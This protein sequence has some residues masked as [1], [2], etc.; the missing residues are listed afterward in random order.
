M[1]LLRFQEMQEPF[2]CS[3][4]S[5]HMEVSP[6]YITEPGKEVF[7]MARL[8]GKERTSLVHDEKAAAQRK[9]RKERAEQIAGGSYRPRSTVFSDK[10]RKKQEAERKRE[11]RS[12]RYPDL[13]FYA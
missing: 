12:Y 10:K 7:K 6:I 1:K 11:I 3:E 8:S 13:S 2:S 4:T 5:L 9:R